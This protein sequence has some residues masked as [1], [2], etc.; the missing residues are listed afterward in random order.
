MQIFMNIHTFSY[1][2]YRSLHIVKKKMVK[3]K[4]LRRNIRCFFNIHLAL[5]WDDPVVRKHR[6]L[7]T[8]TIK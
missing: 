1:Q 4:K 5:F 6:A 3:N 8:N 7:E 2:K